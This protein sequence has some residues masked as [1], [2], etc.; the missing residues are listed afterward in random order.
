MSGIYYDG[1]IGMKPE[2]ENNDFCC[3]PYDCEFSYQVPKVCFECTGEVYDSTSKFAWSK[4]SVIIVKDK[5][6][7]KYTESKFCDVLVTD[8]NNKKHWF[9]NRL[10]DICGFGDEDVE[11]CIERKRYMVEEYDLDKSEKRTY[12]VV[13][14][15]T[16]KLDCSDN[17]FIEKA[18]K[19]KKELDSTEYWLSENL[20]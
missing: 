3:D 20:E 19:I 5:C 17:Y 15:K 7:L 12:A 11:D 13:L 8:A 14:K 10:A 1:M 2:L 4:D 18:L 9:E 6:I 16:E